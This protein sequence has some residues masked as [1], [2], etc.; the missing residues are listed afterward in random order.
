VLLLKDLKFLS[1]H[2]HI[3]LRLAVVH[4]NHQVLLGLILLLQVL[5]EI[6]QLFQQLLQQVVEKV[7][8]TVIVVHQVLYQLM[9]TEV[10][11]VL[12]VELDQMTV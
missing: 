11:V 2:K 3:Q 9:I 1:Q 4:L 7:V 8:D 10:Q 12:V 6:L 5:L